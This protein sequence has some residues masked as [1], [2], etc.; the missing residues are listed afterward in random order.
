MPAI[1]PLDAE[2]LPETAPGLARL[3]IDSVDGGAS[4]GFFAPLDFTTALRWWLA[5]EA[6]LRD[7]SARIWLARQEDRVVGTI[8]LR[9]TGYPTGRHR[10]E[11]SKL[12]VHRDV[13]GQ[14][15]G[16]T[17]LAHAERE[18]LAQEL[19]LLFL[20]TE[21]GS[22][23]ENLYRRSGWTPV[24]TIPDFAHDPRGALSPTTIFYKHLV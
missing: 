23:A 6:P 17:L 15:L 11:V 7:G 3:L 24:G 14:G 9:L 22:V 10:A 4:V 2:E 8:G 19:T 21:T 18:A 5:L 1:T 16:R 12:L 13:R 20:D